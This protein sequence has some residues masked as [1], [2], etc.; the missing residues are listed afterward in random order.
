MPRNNLPLELLARLDPVQVKDYAKA[1]GWV[2]E[3]R[4]GNGLTAV[5]AHPSSDLDQIIVPLNRGGHGFAPAMGDVVNIL[6]EKENRPALE[7]LNDLLLPPSDVLRFT[8]AGTVTASGDVPLNHGIDMLVGARKQV[9]AAACSEIRPERYHPRMSL[10]EAEQLVQQCRLGQTERGSFTVTVACPLHAVPES[11]NLYDQ[12]PFTRRVTALLM[13]SLQRLALALDADELDPLLNPVEGQ[14][15]ISANLCEGLLDMTPEGDGSALTVSASWARTLPPSAAVPLPG[16]VRLRA[17][18]FGRIETLASRLRPVHTPQRQV[19]F[20][21]VDTLN[22]RPN[23]DNQMEGQVILRLVDPESDTIRARTDLKAA[24]YHTAW[25]AHGRN[26][27]IALQG[28][29]RRVGRFSR[30]DEVSDFRLLQQ[31]PVAQAE[32]V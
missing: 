16:T 32:S 13:R 20:G 25:L 12:T 11:Q 17:E 30:I 22:G 7:I 26:Q 3:A 21:F 2:R 15:M 28:I 5:Y 6:A 10:A 8:E 27:P 14:P 4:L 24:D 18:T 9:L 19:L 23:A 29:V 1:T 31:T